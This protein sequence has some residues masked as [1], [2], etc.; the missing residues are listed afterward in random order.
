MVIVLA[1]VGT[2]WA[3]FEL[4]AAMERKARAPMPGLSYPTP[5]MRVLPLDCRKVPE[6][7]EMCKVRARMEKVV[8]K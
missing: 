6:I 1:I 4:G 2:G 3:S 7:R 8:A 5:V